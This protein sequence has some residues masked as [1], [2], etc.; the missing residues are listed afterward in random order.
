M[1]RVAYVA[2]T[3]DTTL[4]STIGFLKSAAVQQ[5][6]L[7]VQRKREADEILREPDPQRFGRGHRW[8]RAVSDAERLR[9]E[10]TALSRIAARRDLEAIFLSKP[11]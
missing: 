10:A 4:K 11:F 1:L 6:R 8:M 5:R 9:A 3:M 2:A 7:S